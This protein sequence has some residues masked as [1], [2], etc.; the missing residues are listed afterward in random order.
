MAS[1]AGLVPRTHLAPSVTAYY[2]FNLKAFTVEGGAEYS[3]PLGRIKPAS[4]A[5][6]GAANGLVTASGGGDYQYGSVASNTGAVS[7]AFT[8]TTS[9]YVSVNGGL[10][11]EDT[12]VDTNFDILDLTTVSN[13]KSSGVWFGIGVSSGF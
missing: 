9:A 4:M 2:D 10:S 5:V 6:S 12:F 8:D 3:V 7:Y 13:P 11:S 1:M